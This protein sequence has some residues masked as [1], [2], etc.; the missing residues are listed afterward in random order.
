VFA[1]FLF[2]DDTD[3]IALSTTKNESANQVLER[4]QAA[5]CTWHGGL[6]ASGGALK[7]EKCSWCL[8]DYSWKEGQWYFTHL[9]DTLYDLMA[10]DLQ[11]TITSIECLDPQK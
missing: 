2:V 3:L 11:G 5:V 1:G 7:P 4:I 6:W 10:P 8:A 9:E